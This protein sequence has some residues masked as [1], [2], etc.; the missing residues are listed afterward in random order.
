MCDSRF[1]D[2]LLSQISDRSFGVSRDRAV[3]IIFGVLLFGNEDAFALHLPTPF[4]PRD[5]CA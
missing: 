3:P 1:G 4:E 5:K 2:V